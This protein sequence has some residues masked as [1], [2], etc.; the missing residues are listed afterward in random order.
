[1]QTNI[2]EYLEQTAQAY[3]NKVAF[4]HEDEQETF[5]SLRAKALNLC[6]TISPFFQQGEPVVIFM[7]KSVRTIL[8]YLA[9]LYGGGFYI[10][11]DADLPLPR[12]QSIVS[13]VG[14]RLILTDHK[15][16]PI[17][18]ELSKASTIYDVQD[19]ESAAGAHG[20][21]D[22]WKTCCDTD[23]MYVIFTSGSTGAP[24]GVVT[25]HRA[26]IDYIDAFAAVASIGPDDVFGNQ[27]PLDYVAAIRD[28]Y[29]P[30]KTGAS[31]VLIPKKLFS[32]PAK[33]F[34]F[35]DEHAITTLCWVVSALCIPVK[36]DA[37]S[38]SVPKYVR[39]VIFTGA[40]MP[41][42]YLAMWQKA[43]PDAFYMN[44][45]GPTE[46]TASCTYHIVDHPVADTEVIP[47]G[48]PYHNTEIILLDEAGRRIT[49]AG[50]KGELC[51]RGTGLAAGYFKDPAKTAEVFTQNPAH[52]LY[53]DIIY[54][55]GDIG[56]RDDDGVLWFHG[57]SDSQIKHMG[58]RIELGEIEHAAKTMPGIGECCCFYQ[59][60]RE[61]L[62]LFYET[63]DVAPAQV[64]AYLR[65]LL[66]AFMIP[67]RLIAMEHFPLRF[68]G[69]IDM[70]ALKAQME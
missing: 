24:K 17:A 57:R 39:K 36:M 62:Y 32:M 65:T 23:A 20:E 14:P 54:H 29:L 48:K 13:L 6:A 3:P 30:L 8:S 34:D 35:L 55:T 25:T 60:E 1:M 45:Y 21:T 51:V 19:V 68:N 46:I 41:A 43:L 42:R 58:H 10:P 5:S 61:L 38:Y 2:L 26:V 37:F 66:P 52:S 67:R 27:A 33:L 56:S 69:K 7:E 44:H 49:A 28:V 15:T 22:R 9:V 47:I 59:A 53:T 40:V 50:E 18:A 11:V 31:T 64:S 70:Q 4:T 16:T 63:T 12:I